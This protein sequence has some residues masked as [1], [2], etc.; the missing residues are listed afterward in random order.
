MVNGVEVSCNINTGNITVHIS[1]DAAQT[2]V[3]RF[4]E[5]RSHWRSGHKVVMQIII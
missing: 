5:L 3:S 2:G 4:G 1:V